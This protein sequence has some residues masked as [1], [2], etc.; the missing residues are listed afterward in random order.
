MRSLLHRVKTFLREE[1]PPLVIGYRFPDIQVSVPSFISTSGGGW[2]SQVALV[3][4][5]PPS[6]AG[7]LR[8]RGEV[9][10]GFN[11]WIR[12]SPWRRAWQPTSVFLPGKIA[13]T[14]VPGGL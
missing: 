8:D 9:G 11:P 4:K 14:E 12:K 10:V 3:V 7:D 6:N 13:Q 2:T 1:Q 5:N